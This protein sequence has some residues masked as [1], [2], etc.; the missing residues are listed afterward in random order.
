MPPPTAII[1]GA[2]S[3][4]G[5]ALTKHL[6]SRNWNVI[7]A[8]VNPPQEKL[9]KT[10]F[11]E[12]DI[13]SWDQ[14]ASM[15]KRAYEWNER[16]DFVA[17]NAGIDDRDD[18]FHSISGDPKKPPRRPGMKTIDV[19]LTGTYYGIKL[20]AH[21][22]SLPSSTATKPQPGG[23]IVLTSSAAGLYPQPV[24][25][26]YAASK[27]ALV[28]LVRSMASVAKPHNITI[29]AVC[30]TLVRTS[31]PPPGLLETFPPDKITPMRTILRAFDELAELEREEW[32]GGGGESGGVDFS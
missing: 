7:M 17:L 1:T 19:N 3:G 11:I 32:R 13:S 25:P 30:P 24:I 26:Q 4:I 2:S 16:L 12:T 15:F 18:V 10:L 27:H 23:K 21:Y 14:Q 6:L 20:A 8:D 5:L 22:L 28:G 31:L 29:N 9:D